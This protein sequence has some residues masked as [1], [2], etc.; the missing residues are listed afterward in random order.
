MTKAYGATSAFGYWTSAALTCLAATLPFTPQ[1]LLNAKPSIPWF[2]IQVIDFGGPILWI[3]ALLCA[4][5]FARNAG[6]TSWWLWLTAPFALWY[7]LLR[8][9]M[10]VWWMIFGFV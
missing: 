8:A 1:R 7:F 10:I 3:V 2:I 5:R 6:R 9:A 4:R